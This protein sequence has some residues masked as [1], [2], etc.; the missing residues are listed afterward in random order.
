M[1]CC[2]RWPDYDQVMTNS[3][4]K[5]IQLLFDKQCKFFPSTN[6]FF[7]S[8]ATQSEFLP[9]LP[10]RLS[11][12]APNCSLFHL[13]EIFL[14]ITLLAWRLC[15]QYHGE[16]WSP[17]FSLVRDLEPS[18]QTSAALLFHFW[19]ATR[20]QIIS[21]WAWFSSLLPYLLKVWLTCTIFLSSLF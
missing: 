5:L 17:N 11:G 12:K 14:M 4:Q 13:Y 8:S 15:C 9:I 19:R 2:I 6:P 18:D 21:R 1:I 20:V 10:P 7:A 3:L 16:R